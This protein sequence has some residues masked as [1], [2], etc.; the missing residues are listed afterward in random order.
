MGSETEYTT[1]L[2]G[3]LTTTVDPRLIA[4]ANHE[5]EVW[6]KNGARLYIDHGDLLEYAS[7]ECMSGSQVLL[8]ERIG[9]FVVRDLG[10]LVD[11]SESERR[12]PVYKRTGYGMAAGTRRDGATIIQWPN[13]S[14]GHHETYQTGLS[15][16]ALAY[17]R[18]FLEAY[19]ATR[20]VWTGAGMV[21][22]DGYRLSQK[23]EA[24]D[25]RSWELTKHGK[26]TGL[27]Y[28]GAGRVEIRT[29]E[30]NM[31]DW[32][33]PRK[34]D[35][36]SLVFRLMEHGQVPFNRIISEGFETDTFR[37]ASRDP[38]DLILA[39]DVR[40]DAIDVQARIAEYALEFAT[41]H[42]VPKDEIVAARDVLAICDDL[43]AYFMEYEDLSVLSDRLDWAAKLDKLRSRGIELGK[44]SCAN[45]VAVAHDLSWEDTSRGGAAER[46]Y[47]TR[48]PATFS[49]ADVR[50]NL[51]NPPSAR[52]KARIDAIRE[53]GD[54]VSWVGWKELRRTG[55]RPVVFEP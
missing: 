54:S 51:G 35:M 25:F 36:T 11:D 42:D 1:G 14:A 53:H 13:L 28:R 19:L 39:D 45:L 20:I 23:A 26:K 31:S 12:L 30:G 44:V 17:Y 5:D 29:G 55:T 46:W 40:M 52:A 43:N 33:I 49:E 38:L 16:E 3:H 37:N 4:F 41:R 24:I 34:F 7:P 27:R 48:Q 32:V 21:A 18:P 6:L 10:A 50:R 2:A 9:Q 22:D 8:H 15:S 47:R